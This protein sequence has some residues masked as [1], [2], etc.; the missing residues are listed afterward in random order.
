[1]KYLLNR[2]FFRQ[3]E[4]YGFTREQLRMIFDDINKDRAVSLGHQ[5][6]KLRVAGQGS[7]KS[8]GFRV[9]F[10]WKREHSAILCYLF[11]KNV[12]EDLSF[13]ELRALKILSK[14]YAALTD[15]DLKERIF[16]GDLKE[17]SND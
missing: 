8:V 9:V 2:Y 16:S 12:Q 4:D 5:L 3:I 13:N 15:A 10:F 11:A 6:Y 17:F 14:E 7:G 1:M